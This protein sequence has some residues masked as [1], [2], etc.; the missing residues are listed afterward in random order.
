MTTPP[1][2]FPLIDG[3]NPSL[4]LIL[5]LVVLSMILVII[6]TIRR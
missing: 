3:S 1:P 2:V 4:F 5:M 6:S